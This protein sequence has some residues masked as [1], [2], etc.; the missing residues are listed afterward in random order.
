MRGRGNAQA[1]Q[2]MAEYA[3]LVAAIAVGCSLAILFVSGGIGELFDSSAKP[4]RTAPF[5]PPAPPPEMTYPTTLADCQAGGWKDFPQF[6]SEEECIDYV[7][8]LT[9]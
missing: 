8:G 9:P 3:I 4:V 2:T 1:G 7:D 6:T 5:R